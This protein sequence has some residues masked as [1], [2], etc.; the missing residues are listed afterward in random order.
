M[1]Y[2]IFE[3]I[4]GEPLNIPPPIGPGG[5]LM[6]GS[7]FDR[8]FRTYIYMGDNRRRVRRMHTYAARLLNFEGSRKVNN[9]VTRII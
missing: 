8:F 6:R 4:V 3:M 5:K 9:H 2:R 7:D 1:N